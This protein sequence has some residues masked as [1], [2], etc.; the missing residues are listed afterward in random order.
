MF[1]AAK[2]FDVHNHDIET[3]TRYRRAKKVIISSDAKI[4]GN[5]DKVIGHFVF[6]DRYNRVLGRETLTFE[7]DN[8]KD[9]FSARDYDDLPMLRFGRFT[10]LLPYDSDGVSAWKDARDY[11]YM[12][13]AKF[14]SL[15]LYHRTHGYE[16]WNW[17]NIEYAW[18]VQTANI[19]NLQI[20]PGNSIEDTMS[21]SHSYDY[22]N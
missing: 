22:H 11:T 19:E 16:L 15:Q 9:S 21:I 2:P 20:S 7:V 6:Y 14:E 8:T 10:S 18:S 12:R 3:M 1:Y 17:H 5:Y 4:E 13:N